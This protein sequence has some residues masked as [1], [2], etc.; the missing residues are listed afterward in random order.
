MKGQTTKLLQSLITGL[1]LASLAWSLYRFWINPHPF[2][3][4]IAVASIGAFVTWLKLSLPVRQV[5]RKAPLHSFESSSP[6]RLAFS[7]NGGE[8]GS[9]SEIPIQRD[10]FIAWCVGAAAGRSIGENHWT[11]STGIFSK[12]EYHHFRDELIARGF[13]RSQGKHHAQGFELTAKGLAMT[14]EVSRRHRPIPYPQR[15]PLFPDPALPKPTHL[16]DYANERE[17]EHPTRSLE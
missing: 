16:S 8:S 6:L 14:R 13:I 2:T 5:L 9:F 7:W 12:A 3:G 4:F 11:G 1:L 17:R 15:S 10:Q